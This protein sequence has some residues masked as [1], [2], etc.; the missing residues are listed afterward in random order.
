MEEKKVNVNTIS[1]WLIVIWI[2]LV[3][4]LFIFLL[5]KYTLKEWSKE[6]PNPYEGETLGLPRGLLRAVLTLSVLFIVMLLQV[7]SLFFDPKDLLVGNEIF[8]PEERFGQ[9]MTAFQMIIAFY[10]G[11]KVMHHYVQAE[12][13]V[14]EKKSD[15]QLEQTKLGKTKDFEDE[16]A[17]G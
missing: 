5:R 10:F 2:A 12:R 8:I 13:R 3:I 11:G 1:M 4:I 17:S 6:N 16:E 9:L 14:E 15:T 7:N